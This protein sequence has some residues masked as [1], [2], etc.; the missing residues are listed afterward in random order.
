[1]GYFSRLWKTING[2]INRS[3]GNKEY[4]SIINLTETAKEQ[5]ELSQKE[6]SNIEDT[7]DNLDNDLNALLT[8]IYNSGGPL[9]EGKTGSIT[10]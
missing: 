3:N 5:L 2:H 6:L 8:S 7:L 10:K 4:M 9:I 1:M